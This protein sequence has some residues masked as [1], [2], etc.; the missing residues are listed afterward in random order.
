[1]GELWDLLARWIDGQQ[2]TGAPLWGH[3]LFVWGRWGKALQFLAGLTVLLDLV[4]PESLRAFGGRLSGISWAKTHGRGHSVLAVILWILACCVPVFGLIAASLAIMERTGQPVPR[5]PQVSS[6]W[7]LAGMG[8]FLLTWG[9]A[10]LVFHVTGRS[11]GS[12]A[13]ADAFVH[14]PDLWAHALIAVFF[15]VPW[16]LVIYGLC[17]PVAYGLAFLLDRARPAH[18]A[19]WFALGLFLVGFLFDFL[20]S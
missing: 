9:A 6:Y 14:V 13:V 12:D 8:L 4:G 10:A 11:T 17:L 1:M 3:P 18:P 20:A 15:W 16:T 19:R 5:L 2:L 7:L